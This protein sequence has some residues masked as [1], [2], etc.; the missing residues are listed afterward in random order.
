MNNEQLIMNNDLARMYL[1]CVNLLFIIPHW[2][3][4]CSRFIPSFTL[5]KKDIV[6]EGEGHQP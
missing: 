4:D 6:Q 2:Q 1:G 3:T 5:F